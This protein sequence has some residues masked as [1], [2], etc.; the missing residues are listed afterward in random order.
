MHFPAGIPLQLITAIRTRRV[1]VSKLALLLAVSKAPVRVC[2]R[3]LFNKMYRWDVKCFYRFKA[4]RHE[5][6]QEDR[7]LFFSLVKAE[8]QPLLKAVSGL[9]FLLEYINTSPAPK[10]PGIDKMG[11]SPRSLCCPRQD[12]AKTEFIEW[13]LG[14]S[15][16]R[17][18]QHW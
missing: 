14:N 16:T 7:W 3:R 18:I 5:T 6:K 11:T 10:P 9:A 2:H 17:V 13:S 4:K 1:K 15:I 8:Q 12:K